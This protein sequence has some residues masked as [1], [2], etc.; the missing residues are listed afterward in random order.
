VAPVATSS[1]SPR[2]RAAD[3]IVAFEVVRAGTLAAIQDLGRYGFQRYGVLVGGAMDE[4][5]HRLANALLGNDENDATLEMV[6]AGPTLLLHRS[7]RVATCGADMTPKVSGLTG[8]EPL[9][10]GRPV[11]LREGARIDFGAPRSGVHAY[12][13]VCGGFAVPRVMGSR[14]TY[15]RGGFGGL[16]GRALATGDRLDVAQHPVRRPTTL[17]PTPADFA[18]SSSGALFVP[19]SPIVVAPVVTA[20]VETVRVIAGAQQPLFTDGARERLFASEYRIGLQSDRMG[21]RLEGPTLERTEKTEMISEAVT[22]GTLQVPPDGLPIVL[23]ADRQTAGG[24]PKFGEVA[25]AD[26]KVLAQMAPRRRLR[27]APIAL[28]DAQRIL[29]AREREYSHVRSMMGDGAG[30]GRP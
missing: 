21:Y 11:W 13:A 25:S 24:Y 2:G 20:E 27:F 12:L 8:S 19:P 9:P 22:F 3:A 29:L 30:R 17:P 7:I 6:L 28:A 10:H 4:W 15:L 1:D 26:L 14:S 23:M 16:G 5:S 18:R